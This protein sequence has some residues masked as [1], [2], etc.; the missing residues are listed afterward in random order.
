MNSFF[1]YL[2][3]SPL[4]SFSDVTFRVLVILIFITDT[5]SAECSECCKMW[6]F[7]W[8]KVNKE[9]LEILEV[10]KSLPVELFVCILLG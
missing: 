9:K 6:C 10:S 8:A 2:L 1:T 5:F 7:Q 4:S 3:L